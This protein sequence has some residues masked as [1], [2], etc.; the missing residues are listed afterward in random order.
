MAYEDD[1]LVP[2]ET[3]GLDLTDGVPQS[4]GGLGSADSSCIRM[5]IIMRTEEFG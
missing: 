5:V 2:L 1:G 3:T 4:V